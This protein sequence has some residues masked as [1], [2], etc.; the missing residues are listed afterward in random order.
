MKK[1]NLCWGLL[2]LALSSNNPSYLPATYEEPLPKSRDLF[3]TSTSC[4]V[5]IILAIQTHSPSPNKLQWISTFS[6]LISAAH[7]VPA[8]DCSGAYST[9]PP[10]QIAAVDLTEVEGCDHIQNAYL[11]RVPKNIQVVKN[12]QKIPY[13]FFTCH[14]EA[15]IE[16][17]HC[18]NRI[19]HNELLGFTPIFTG[20]ILEFDHKRCLKAQIS[21]E[22]FV[23]LYG[24]Y[25]SIKFPDPKKEVQSLFYMYGV[26]DKHSGCKGADFNLD[27]VNYP[28]GVLR[29]HLKASMKIL[30]GFLDINADTYVLSDKLKF[31]K[32]QGYGFNKVLGMVSPINGSPTDEI[33]DLCGRMRQIFQGEGNQHLPLKP[34]K[35]K[36]LIIVRQKKGHSFALALGPKISICGREFR[37][38]QL[39]DVFVTLHRDNDQNINFKNIHAI[40]VSENLNLVSMISSNFYSNQVSLTKAFEEIT[41][42]LCDLEKEDLKRDLDHMTE[43]G[44]ELVMGSKLGTTVIEKGAVAYIIRCN[45]IEVAINYDFGKCCNNLPVKL[46]MKNKTTLNLFLNAKTQNLEPNC[47]V[48][49]CSLLTP[50]AFK[51]SG[52]NNSKIWIALHPKPIAAPPPTILQP[53]QSRDAYYS[54]EP[55]GQGGLFSQAQI[56]DLHNSQNV[57]TYEKI[58][59][60]TLAYNLFSQTN[61]GFTEL[62]KAAPTSY[63]S[64]ISEQIMPNWIKLAP[65]GAMECYLIF[66]L[67]FTVTTIPITILFAMNRMFLMAVQQ[68]GFFNMEVL[69]AAFLY[70]FITIYDWKKARN[71]MNKSRNTYQKADNQNEGEELIVFS[72]QK[73]GATK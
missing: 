49:V 25:F 68:N 19:F 42:R 15:T 29:A 65:T 1:E 34:G 54:P 58:I 6:F 31:S 13:Q 4:L 71:E 37:S 24:S 44:G 36:E 39:K 57:L 53:L 41:R 22:I 7:A 47:S 26:A 40:E 61:T 56:D 48:T 14:V 10:K 5:T 23:P 55:L 69:K 27:G 32:Q 20:K 16:I 62:F 17:A 50:P 73:H 46:V 60:P 21:N 18:Q 11:E 45:K 33:E 28:N 63:F 12:V 52:K 2:L 35:L 30:D 9:N 64:Y 43:R 70:N 3:S 59:G 66:C 38:T 72:S 67:I 51:I 8:F